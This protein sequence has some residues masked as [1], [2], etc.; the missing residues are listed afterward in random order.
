MEKVGHYDTT[1]KNS[2]CLGTKC[3]RQQF[4]QKYENIDKQ[5]FH[6]FWEHMYWHMIINFTL[7]RPFHGTEVS[8]FLF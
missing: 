2:V 8:V 3:T 6:I 7:V 1:G 5:V 4:K